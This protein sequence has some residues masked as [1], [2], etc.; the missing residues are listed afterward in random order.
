MSNSNVKHKYLKYKM[1]YVLAIKELNKLK[2]GM[3]KQSIN[4]ICICNKE[5]CICV[6]IDEIK[7]KICSYCNK[8]NN[9]ESN[10]CKVCDKITQLTGRI[11]KDEENDDDFESDPMYKTGPST[12]YNEPKKPIVSNQVQDIDMK[13]VNEMKANEMLVHDMIQNEMMSRMKDN[14]SKPQQSPDTIPVSVS[15]EK[16]EQLI[17]FPLLEEDIQRLPTKKEI[18]TNDISDIIDNETINYNDMMKS[19]ES[20]NEMDDADI[21]KFLNL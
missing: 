10:A 16:I 5:N 2:G 21:R 4:I 18:Q 3:E 20:E 6:N 12:Y 19:T 9:S 7:S 8:S 17:D 15:Q 1:K 13:Q 11:N 14:M